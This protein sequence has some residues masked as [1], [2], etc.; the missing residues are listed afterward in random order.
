[1][2]II[3]V[4]QLM[5][6][7]NRHG[8]AEDIERL[9]Q[10][11]AALGIYDRM[12]LDFASQILEGKPYELVSDNPDHIERARDLAHRLGATEREAAAGGAMTSIIFDPPMRRDDSPGAA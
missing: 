8:R 6:E 12:L 3:A 2:D 1:M 4:A 9:D 11:R 7:V 5:H 10:E